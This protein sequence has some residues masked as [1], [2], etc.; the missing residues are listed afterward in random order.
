MLKI[1]S[2]SMDRMMIPLVLNW[3]CCPMNHGQSVQ[4]DEDDGVSLSV[5]V[6]REKNVADELEVRKPT[7]NRLFQFVTRRRNLSNDSWF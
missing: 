5:V 2:S 7:N 6:G 3:Y 1:R 4:S